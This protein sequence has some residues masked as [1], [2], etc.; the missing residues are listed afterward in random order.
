[1]RVGGAIS[2]GDTLQIDLFFLQ[3]TTYLLMIDEA[4]RFK[5]C[6]VL[7]G[8]DSEHIMEALMKS[9]IYLF[10]PPSKI[11]MDQQVSL[12]SHDSGAEFERL[13]I[14][15]VPKGTTSGAAAKQHTGT[16]I[17]VRHVDLMKLTMLKL[18]AEMSRQGVTLENEEMA[19][20]AAMAQNITLSYGGVTP[21]MCVRDAAQ[22]ILRGGWSWH[23][24]YK[25]CSSN[26]FDH[27]RTS[28]T[29]PTSCIGTMSSGHQ[30]G[31][32]RPCF[33]ESTTA[34]G[35]PGSCDGNFGGGILS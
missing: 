22:R 35:Y 10:G 24:V 18:Q 27:V 34:I 23:F 17:V 20:E 31:S 14:T 6:R 19:G 30:R 9:W 11:V 3:D 25:R 5:M 8:Q 32:H 12:M 29:Y 33:K 13:N 15:R 7:P 2:F 4:T 1:M 26:G 16:G 21:A 28:S